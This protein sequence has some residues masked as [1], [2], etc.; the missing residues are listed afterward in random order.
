[1]KLKGDPKLG[2]QNVF[3]CSEQIEQVKKVLGTSAWVN[4]RYGAGSTQYSDVVVH[5]FGI[6][7]VPEPH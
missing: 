2:R 6:E 5:G 4:L 7:N 3:G 1:M